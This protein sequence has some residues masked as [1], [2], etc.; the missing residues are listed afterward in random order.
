[1]DAPVSSL[2]SAPAPATSFAPYLLAQV[3]SSL[4]QRYEIEL[5]CEADPRQR[6]VE[7]ARCRDDIEYWF[8]N[9]VDTYDPRFISDGVP[10]TMPFVL[11]PRQIEFLKWLRRME[12]EQKDGSCEKSREVGV[13]WLFCGYGAH[14]WLFRSGFR[15]GVT[16][17]T[18]PKVDKIGEMKSIFEKMRFILR[19]LP[20]WMMPAGFNWVRHDTFCKLTNPAIDSS[21][22]GEVGDQVGRGDRV[23]MYIVD[24]AAYLEHP[25]RAA[26]ALS[27]TTRCRIDVSTPHGTHTPFY[28]RL[29][30]L[31]PEQRF[32]FHWHD[33]PRKDQAWYEAERIRIGDPRLVAQELDIDHAAAAE[34]LEFPPEFFGPHILF[35]EWPP[36]LICKVMACDP[37]KGKQDRSGDYSAWVML[38]VDPQ[39]T[40][41]ADADLD[42]ARPVEP[43]ASSPDMRSIVGDG[44]RLI[45]EFKPEAILV[46]AN[47]FQEWVAF[48]LLRYARERGVFLS[49]YTVAHTI[50]K[51]QRIRAGLSPY[52]AQKRLR[53]R[54]TPGGRVLV[55]QT[56]EYS[57]TPGLGADHD[58]G[59]DCLATAEEI[60]DFILNGRNPDMG[61]AGIQVLQ[62]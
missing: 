55:Q 32:R 3:E 46:E 50:S 40:L 6:A 38:G 49:V 31:P 5:A 62:A 1:V 33:D 42:N 34:G 21:I 7:Y 14:S 17:H 19:R 57:S 54:N 24:E 52:L 10:A 41:W 4:V 51:G 26:A 48:A 53:V 8:A 36:D 35:D 2:A 29:T 27:Q 23:T 47:G 43:L 45:Q 15:M 60:A 9:Y 59:P 20:T 22:T 12:V 25:D 18:E 13:T 61:G 28:K 37:S 30:S 44:F 56:R 39:W 16:S 11:F 58:D